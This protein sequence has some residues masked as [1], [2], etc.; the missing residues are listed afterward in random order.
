MPSGYSIFQTA[1]PWEDF[2]T[3]SRDMR[4][5]IAID[6]V[7]DLPKALRRNPQRF[8]MTTNEVQA[9]LPQLKKDLEQALKS[10]Q[11]EY[12]K[13]DGTAHTLTLWDL[14][15]RQSAFEVAYNPNDYVEIRWGAPQDSQ[16]YTTCKRHAP[17][18]QLR[19]MNKYRAWFN[20]RKRPPRGTR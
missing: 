9:T 17:R 13:S 20:E 19:K 2:A 1:G 16:E 7:L 8:G 3:P 11:F 6:T 15:Q 5:L 4:L 10:R 18:S 12:T 14:T